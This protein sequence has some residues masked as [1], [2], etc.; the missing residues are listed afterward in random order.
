[1]SGEWNDL[2]KISVDG[3]DLNS[4]ISTLYNAEQT[5]TSNLNQDSDKYVSVDIDKPDEN[6]VKKIVTFFAIIFFIISVPI[7][8]HNVKD[9]WQMFHNVAENETI[10]VKTTKLSYKDLYDVSEVTGLIGAESSVDVVARVDGYLEKTYFKDGDFVKQGQLLFTIEPNEYKISVRAAEAEVAQAQA[11]H[12]NSLQ[13]LERAKA[14][15]KEN[16]ISKS[17]YDS[18]VAT[19]SSTSA[20]LDAAR[21]SLAR[22]RLNLGY[23]QIQAPISGKVGKINLSNG[24]YVGLQSGPLVTIAKMNPIS[25]N[26]S[27]KSADVLRMKRGDSGNFD[28]A[29]A[30]VELLLSDDTKYNKIG[31][32]TF[33]D[34]IVSSDSA[35]LSLKAVFD[36]SENILIPGDYVRVIITSK[37]PRRKL[38]VPQSITRGDAVNG[39]YLW[40]VEN[41]KTKKKRLVIGG[42]HENDWI[43]ESGV[44]IDDEIVKYSN[45]PIDMEQLSVVV[46]NSTDKKGNS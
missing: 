17:D 11:V 40:A 4:D 46:N 39:Y 18:I 31:K 25:V 1:M 36:N 35:S 30:K 13:E 33:L 24:N 29:T 45:K 41:G 32:I 3:I 9:Y 22:A 5:G 27:L 42:S 7:I 43:V 26:F 6:K 34:N 21:Q 10:T 12:T 16:F 38:V 28:I 2:P 37:E 14:L 19:A 23:T 15:V 8:Y 20:S 44:N